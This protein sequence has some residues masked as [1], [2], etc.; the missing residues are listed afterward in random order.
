MNDQERLLD[1]AD[2]AR[3]LDKQLR[4]RSKLYELLGSSEL[5]EEFKRLADVEV[6]PIIKLADERSC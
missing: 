3:E 6:R 1:I 5:A 4:E 2:R